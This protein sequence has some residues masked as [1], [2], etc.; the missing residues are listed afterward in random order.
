[1]PTLKILNVQKLY[2]Q[3]HAS[4]NNLNKGLLAKLAALRRLIKEQYSEQPFPISNF[5]SVLKKLG[6]YKLLFC[7]TNSF[8]SSEN[9]EIR[10]QKAFS[11]WFHIK[12][13]FRQYQSK[14][15]CYR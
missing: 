12:R 4:D 2:Y 10:F 8:I 15:D 6:G 11:L 7:S 14:L 9:A 5:S 1:M 13:H 3:E